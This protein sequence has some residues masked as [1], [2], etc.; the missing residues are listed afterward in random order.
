MALKTML[1]CLSHLLSNSLSRSNISAWVARTFRSLMNAL[2]IRSPPKSRRPSYGLAGPLVKRPGGLDQETPAIHM[3]VSNPLKA[4]TIEIELK[5]R[6]VPQMIPERV[7]VDLLPK[8]SPG[9]NQKIVD[10]LP[11]HAL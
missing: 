8:L 2:M 3:P 4:E 11:A 1:N 6:S 10:L 9:V 5:V 7:P